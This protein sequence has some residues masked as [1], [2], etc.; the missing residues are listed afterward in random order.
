MALSPTIYANLLGERIARHG[1]QVETRQP[2]TARNSRSTS[3]TG[4]S[5]CCSRSCR[6]GGG[7][8]SCVRGVVRGPGAATCGYDL[9]LL[10]IVAPSA[11]PRV[12]LLSAWLASRSAIS[13]DGRSRRSRSRRSSSASRRWGCGCGA[14][15]GLMRCVTLPLRVMCRM[16]LPIQSNSTSSISFQLRPCCGLGVEKS[17]LTSPK[18]FGTADGHTKRR[19]RSSSRDHRDLRA[20]RSNDAVQSVRLR[21]R[22]ANV[23]SLV[24][25]VA[26]RDRAGV[27]GDGDRAA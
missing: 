3:L 8:R 20:S 15:G 12:R 26:V 24:P 1:A 21:R 2:P 25:R 14:I 27:A 7:W 11:A 17:S 16:P 10:L 22:C 18:T 4:P 6:R 5:R 23:P 9:E 19:T 13:A